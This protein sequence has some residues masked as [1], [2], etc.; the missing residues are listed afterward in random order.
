[1][2]L[3]KKFLCV[4]IG[5][6]YGY[7]GWR[8]RCFSEAYGQCQRC[9]RAEMHTFIPGKE[10]ERVVISVDR[11]IYKSKKG[12]PHVSVAEADRR[13]TRYSKWIGCAVADFLRV[14]A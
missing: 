11:A 1:M 2:A 3:L 9:G 12:L 10:G 6:D 13:R 14:A 8:W 5:H 4:C 7:Y